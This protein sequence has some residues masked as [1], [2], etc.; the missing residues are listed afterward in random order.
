MC[1]AQKANIQMI[2]LFLDGDFQDLVSHQ[3]TKLYSQFP[4]NPAT[5]SQ[6]LTFGI[7]QCAFDDHRKKFV[8]PMMTA[9]GIRNDKNVI[10]TRIELAD[11]VESRLPIFAK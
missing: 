5:Y 8:T 1:T 6:P 3:F 2:P 9:F 11:D 7:V 4:P 10:R